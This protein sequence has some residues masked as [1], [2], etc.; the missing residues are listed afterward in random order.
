MATT[1]VRLDPEE[2]EMLAQLAPYYGG[3]S[4]VLRQALRKLSDEAKNRAALASFV[5][6]WN[7]ADGPPEASEIADMI[8]KF[9][10]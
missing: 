7:D 8:E 1:T 10:H 5:A 3:K 6:D 4:S 2:A 9:D